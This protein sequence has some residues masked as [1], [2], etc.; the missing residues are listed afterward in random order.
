MKSAAR[1]AHLGG[2]SVKEAAARVADAIGANILPNDLAPDGTAASVGS[3]G[4][5]FFAR[6]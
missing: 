6:F 5:G 3:D 4:R 2:D 1:Y